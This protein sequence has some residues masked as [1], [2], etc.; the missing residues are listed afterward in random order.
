MLCTIVQITYFFLGN[1]FELT[2]SDIAKYSKLGKCLF[3]WLD[4]KTCMDFN[5]CADVL[6]VFVPDDVSN[7]IDCPINQ[8]NCYL[9]PIDNNGKCLLNL[10]KNSG[11]LVCSI[12][13]RVLDNSLVYHACFSKNG[14][15]STV[16][17]S[18][19]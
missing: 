9:N 11:V 4:D 3:L 19:A 16:D 13:G 18:L 17:Y 1:V 12:N 6:L 15:P 8:N 2:E 7:F 5:Y 14:N 10:C